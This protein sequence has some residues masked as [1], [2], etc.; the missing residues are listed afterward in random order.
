MNLLDKD[1]RILDLP[2]FN[3]SNNK[4]DNI[5]Y[6]KFKKISEYIQIEIINF[7][8]S[9]SLHKEQKI[10]ILLKTGIKAYAS[11]VA[12]L[13]LKLCY[14]PLNT[15]NSIEYNSELISRVKP[16][17][18]ITDNNNLIKEFK[19]ISILFDYKEGL[20]NSKK[21]S[22]FRK[23]NDSK[24]NSLAYIIF[25]SGTTGKPKG[26]EISRFNLFNYLKYC[27]KNIPYKENSKVLQ[28][29][30][31][32]FDLSV[33]S[34]YPPLI[35]G[36][37]IVSLKSHKEEFVPWNILD[38]EKINI[39][40]SVPSFISLI[41]ASG[42]L[43]SKYFE[44]K[45]AFIFCGEA[46][47]HV[48]VSK[49]FDNLP[50]SRIFNLYG[51]TEVTVSCSEIELNK[52]NFESYSDGVNLSI[53]K[54]INS[55]KFYIKSFLD[56]DGL[57]KNT[58]I[59]KGPQVAKGYFNNEEL[60]NERFQKEKEK[61]NSYDTGDCVYLR[62]DGN[63]F[64][65]NRN[66]RQIKISGYRIELGEVESRVLESGV[67]EVLAIAS[68]NFIKV[69]FYSHKDIDKDDIELLLQKKFPHYYRLKFIEEIKPLQRTKNGKFDIRFYELR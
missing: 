18:I 26:V 25:T 15:E 24:N 2:Q 22:Y 30:S 69:F 29:A 8:N 55:H 14:V 20:N 54:P 36:S 17:I 27:Y 40:T 32:S 13:D 61:I 1:F 50:F 43:N 57:K 35:K 33:L 59:I 53:G 47:N 46:L 31:I 7:L 10:I 52:K 11:M 58:L 37:T 64:F 38:K 34:I 62:D 19:D 60:T 16:N 67:D 4:I 66:D 51:P 39:I 65:K 21:N 63:Y 6:K 44:K 41:N 9:K 56:R 5:S 45:I 48:L 49:I 42:K 3:S 68:K 23:V 12:C 28:T